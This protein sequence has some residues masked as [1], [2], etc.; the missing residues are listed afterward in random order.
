M[1]GE[2]YFPRYTNSV[3]LSKKSKKDKKLML[4]FQMILSLKCKLIF[5]LSCLNTLMLSSLMM[6]KHKKIKKQNGLAK[7]QL[8]QQCNLKVMANLI[9]NNLQFHIQHLLTSKGYMLH[10]PKEM[11]MLND[12]VLNKFKT[13]N[14]NGYDHHCKTSITHKQSNSLLCTNELNL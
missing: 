14:N 3:N 12:V 9:E 8:K 13:K 11:Q 5:R 7:V 10:K 1:S 2:H 4:T 6:N